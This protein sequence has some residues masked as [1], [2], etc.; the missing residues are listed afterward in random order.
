MEDNSDWLG[1]SEEKTLEPNLKICDPHHHF[2]E[3]RDDQTQSRYLLDDILVDI[4]SGHNIVS[5]VYTSMSLG[6]HDGR[7]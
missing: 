5:T 3:F 1:L 7:S 6:V 4:N 2:W